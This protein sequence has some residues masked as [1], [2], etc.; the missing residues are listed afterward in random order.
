MIL[1]DESKVLKI[2]KSLKTLKIIKDKRVD[3]SDFIHSKNLFD[4]NDGRDRKW[5]LTREEYDLLKEVLKWLIMCIVKNVNIKK[6][7]TD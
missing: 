4:Y 7:A 5:K 6:I 1:I 3:I 2:I